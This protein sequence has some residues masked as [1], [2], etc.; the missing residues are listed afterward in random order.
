M[1]PAR[2]TMSAMP[3]RFEIPSLIRQLVEFFA[4][5]LDAASDAPVQ[6]LYADVA[7]H[8][9]HIVATASPRYA[10]RWG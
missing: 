10:P 3:S 9:A 8:G 1:Q 5:E 2:A 6:P 4:P 7:V